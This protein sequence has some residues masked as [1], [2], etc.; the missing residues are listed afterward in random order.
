M[1]SVPFPFN[2]K[3]ARRVAAPKATS[4]EGFAARHPVLAF[5]ANPAQIAA[6]EDMG[7]QD[8]FIMQEGRGMETLAARV[9]SFRDHPGTLVIVSEGRVFGESKKA[10]LAAAKMIEAAGLTVV[11][12]SHPEHTLLSEHIEFALK[13]ISGNPRFRNRRAQRRTASKGGAAT[14]SKAEAKRDDLI[15]GDILS[16]LIA[17]AGLSLRALEKALN[18]PLLNLSALSRHKAR[19]AT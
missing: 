6:L 19:K 1:N 8:R 9:K 7:W 18:H 3:D 14:A 2:F 11:D 4:L 15:R 17:R 16:N 12:Y 10:I 5:S 13:A